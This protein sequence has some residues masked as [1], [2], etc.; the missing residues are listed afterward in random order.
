MNAKYLILPFLFYHRYRLHKKRILL[1]IKAVL[2]S[3]EKHQQELIRLSNQ[4][5]GFAET[6]KSS[7][8]LADYAQ[9]QG[10]R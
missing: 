10:F 9:E 5:W 2:A 3:V 6:M 7:K 1:L 4:I 8:V